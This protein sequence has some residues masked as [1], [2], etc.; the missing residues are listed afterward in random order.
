MAILAFQLKIFGLVQG[1]SY[2]ASLKSI[3]EKYSVTGWV[4]NCADG[5]V[6]ARLEGNANEI[7]AVFQWA[8]VGPQGARVDK[9]ELSP[10]SPENFTSF[11]IVK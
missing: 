9:V 7:Q 10:A 8:E 11:A 1:V 5:T 6:E 3:A 4:S 2:R